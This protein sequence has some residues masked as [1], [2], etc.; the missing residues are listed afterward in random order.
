MNVQYCKLICYNFQDFLHDRDGQ[1]SEFAILYEDRGFRSAGQNFFYGNRKPFLLENKHTGE[2]LELKWFQNGDKFFVL[3]HRHPKIGPLQSIER[4]Y[5]FI[6]SN[7]IQKKYVKL[8]N[9][10]KRSTPHYVFWSLTSLFRSSKSFYSDFLDPPYSSKLF[11]DPTDS[12]IKQHFPKF[13]K[14]KLPIKTFK[15]TKKF[16]KFYFHQ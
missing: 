16:Q 12:S 4:L 1:Q 8:H 10:K 6:N 5:L 14:S 2:V 15:T 11:L 13:K 3:L 7:D 9:Y